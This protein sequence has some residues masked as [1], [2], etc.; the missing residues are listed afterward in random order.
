MARTRNREVLDG[1]LNFYSNAGKTIANGIA[2]SN[3]ITSLLTTLVGSRVKAALNPSGKSAAR[4]TFMYKSGLPVTEGNPTLLLN[5]MKDAEGSEIGVACGTQTIS[6]AAANTQRVILD[7]DLGANVAAKFTGNDLIPAFVDYKEIH[8]FY[9]ATQ[10]CVVPFVVLLEN[11]E[12]LTAA[13]YAAASVVSAIQSALPAQTRNIVYGPMGVA[14]QNADTAGVKYTCSL[15]VNLRGFAN[16][17]SQHYRKF[18]MEERSPLVLQIGLCFIGQASQ[19]II[20]NYSA[21]LPYQQINPD[22]LN[23]VK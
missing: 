18:S 14:R 3:P 22:L 15:T 8:Y 4:A 19:N 11:G 5:D 6:I 16:A 10:F 2:I 21:I 23:E 7:N 1:I 13:N 9:S 20:D 12:T 17:Y